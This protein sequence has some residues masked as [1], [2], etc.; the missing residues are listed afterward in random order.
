MMILDWTRQAGHQ[1]ARGLRQA[2]IQ[3]VCRPVEVIVLCT[4]VISCVMYTLWHHVPTPIQMSDKRSVVASTWRL[5]KDSDRFVPWTEETASHPSDANT[6]KSQDGHEELRVRLHQLVMMAPVHRSRKSA[7]IEQWTF[8][9]AALRD[10]VQ[11]LKD[12]LPQLAS[13]IAEEKLATAIR[14]KSTSSNANMAP[15]MND[16]AD[17]SLN[18]LRLQDICMRSAQ[19]TG[20]PESS[21]SNVTALCLRLPSYCIGVKGAVRD[22]KE[23]RDQYWHRLMSRL[24]AAVDDDDNIY[25]RAAHNPSTATIR[26]PDAAILSYVLDSTRVSSQTDDLLQRWM[27]MVI[28]TPM[29]TSVHRNI[30]GVKRGFHSFANGHHSHSIYTRAWEASWEIAYNI[31]A[32]LSKAGTLELTVVSTA[33]VLLHVTIGM[34]FYKLRRIGSRWTLGVAAIMCSIAAFSMA[35]CTT[36]LL[37]CSIDLLFFSEAIPFLVVIVGFEKPYALAKAVILAPVPLDD[38][39]PLERLAER[40]VFNGLNKVLPRVLRDYLFEISV[41]VFGIVSGVPGLSEFCVLSAATLTFDCLLQFTVF[42][43]VL[44][45]KCEL[46]LVRREREQARNTAQDTDTADSSNTSTTTITTTAGGSS[47]LSVMARSAR[48]RLSGHVRHPSVDGT[49]R[50]LNVLRPFLSERNAKNGTTGSTN[51]DATQSVVVARCKLFMMIAFMGMHIFNICS[52]FHGHLPR[53]GA[54]IDLSNVVMAVTGH[55]RPENPIIHGPLMALVADYRQSNE[56]RPLVV[57]LTTPIVF[58]AQRIDQEF[59]FAETL[60]TVIIDSFGGPLRGHARN[61]TYEQLLTIGLFVSL[62]ANWYLYSGDSRRGRRRQ[63]QHPHSSIVSDSPTED[64]ISKEKALLQSTPAPA[65]KASSTD[66]TATTSTVMTT[67]AVVQPNINNITTKTETPIYKQGDTNDNRSEEACLALLASTPSEL[68]DEEVIMLVQ[69]NKLPG[70]AL[71]KR[72]GDFER[73]VKIRRAVTSR[74]SITGTLE[75]SNLPMQHYDYARVIGQ[76]CENVIGYTPIPIGVAGPIRIDGK[77]YHIPMTTTEGCL[78]ASTS[79]GCKAISAGG[80]SATTVVVNDGMTRGPAAAECKLW[81]DN[82]EGFAVML[83]GRLA[84]IR[85]KATTGDAMG[86]NMISKGVE[87]ALSTLGERYADMQIVSISGNTCSDKKPAAVNWIEGRG[88]ST[89]AECTISGDIV[90]SVLKTTVADLNLIGSAMAGS[91][92]GFNAH[93]SNILTAIYLATGQDPAQN[94]E[95]SQCI[96]LMQAVNDGQ[97][98][99]ISCTM[100]CIEVGTIGGGTQLPAQ[101]AC[102]DMLGVRGA[103]ATLPGDNARQLARIICAS[104]MAGELSLCAA[105]AAGHLVKSHMAH[106]RA[107]PT[108]ANTAATPSTTNSSSPVPGSCLRS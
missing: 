70:Y 19:S 91:V 44:T 65:S 45:L 47:A 99:H 20:Q 57:E 6:A 92:G 16:T 4:V 5:E 40:Q 73:A 74:A 43:A 32:G 81:I 103:H 7:S 82:G 58:E 76:C 1:L 31:I 30:E 55:L 50:R 41:L 68:T 56:Q 61:A 93:A 66:N 78:V 107:A 28:D 51:S 69:S 75:N 63:E 48:R 36:G 8:S 2:A 86:M 22:V 37:G 39:V 72:L 17:S 49:T 108:A 23:L 80:K 25:T 14:R 102:L 3:S 95:S 13:S 88:K 105:L 12:T 27:S 18:V 106:N 46:N 98:L 71:E 42:A 89:L 97:D 26:P 11:E 101:A 38:N 87:K 15:T 21:A 83:A 60:M 85:F 64:V 34:L 104:V 9:A 52:A 67:V 54:E 62:M 24:E 100:P 59:S 96:T 77:L 84:F 90:R 53:P 79:R 35:L 94:V 29:D 10:A 33:Y